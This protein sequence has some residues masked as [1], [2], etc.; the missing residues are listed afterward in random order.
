MDLHTVDAILALLGDHSVSEFLFTFLFNFRYSTAPQLCTF[1]KQ[2]P[3][4][5]QAIGSHPTLGALTEQ[6]MF[7]A[8]ATRLTA[9]VKCLAEKESGW[10]ISAKHARAD[11]LESFSLDG[12]SS[13]MQEQ[14]PVLSKLLGILLDSDPQRS[15]RQAQFAE[16]SEK[17]RE[18]C[19]TDTGSM[20]VDWDDE[21]EYWWE[22]DL[23]MLGAHD[24]DEDQLADAGEGNVR[25][26]TGSS[27][28]T[29]AATKRE[30]LRKRRER[31]V[32]RRAALI[33]I[34]SNI[35]CPIDYLN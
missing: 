26:G 25:G 12:M 27:S 4:L 24:G 30:R 2:W 9:E 19:S 1:V 20:A 3:S 28:V 31:A 21:D 34:V 5:L 6:F 32:A 18:H 15:T 35:F 14:A 23:D 13:R 33:S 7:E 8:F 16:G 17:E 10:H 29:D 11:Q 22:A